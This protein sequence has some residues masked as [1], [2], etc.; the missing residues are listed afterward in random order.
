M[1]VGRVYRVPIKG[2]HYEPRDGLLDLCA[3][4]LTKDAVIII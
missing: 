1:D 3:N 2:L 4:S